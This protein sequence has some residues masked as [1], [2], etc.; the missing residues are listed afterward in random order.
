MSYYAQSDRIETLQEAIS[1]SR[2]NEGFLTTG[3]C[4]LCHK[5]IANQY[6]TMD[7]SIAA[8]AYTV[9]AHI[10]AKVRRAA[11]EVEI[12]GFVRPMYYH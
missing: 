1:Y 9:P 5:E 7:G 12:T 4:M 6:R 10:E 8:P 3:E 2:T 11:K